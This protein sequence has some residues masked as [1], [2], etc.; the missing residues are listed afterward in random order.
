MVDLMAT[1]QLGPRA[2]TC[3]QRKLNYYFASHLNE[4]CTTNLSGQSPALA[5]IVNGKAQKSTVARMAGRPDQV[6]QCNATSD[7]GGRLLRPASLTR[8]WVHGVRVERQCAASHRPLLCTTCA[9]ATP[10]CGGKLRNGDG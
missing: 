4:K 9:T 6:Q 10:C 5:P 1:S 2:E 3:G 7:Q 8:A